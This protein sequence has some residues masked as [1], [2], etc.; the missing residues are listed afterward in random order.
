MV[1]FK[2]NVLVH[3]VNSKYCRYWTTALVPAI[4][5]ICHSVE[6]NVQLE[7]ILI[8]WSVIKWPTSQ[9]YLKNSVQKSAMY[10][11]SFNPYYCN[12][13]HSLLYSTNVTTCQCQHCCTRWSYTKGKVYVV[14]LSWVATCYLRIELYN[15][16]CL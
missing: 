16:L 9:D 15:W 6:C 10:S 2:V 4:Q 7:V 12:N 11:I 13:V 14:E 1:Y 3:W 5:E 8:L